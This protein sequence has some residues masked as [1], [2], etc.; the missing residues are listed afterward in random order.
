MNNLRKIA[1]ML[2]IGVMTLGMFGV[3][4][5]RPMAQSQVATPDNSSPDVS[6]PQTVMDNWEEYL[7]ESRLDGVLD[8]VLASYK[9]T[10]VAPD[11][12]ATNADGDVGVLVVVNDGADL[13]ALENLVQVNWKA[14]FKVATVVSAYVDSADALTELES[15]EGVA[16]VFADQTYRDTGSDLSARPD[17]EQPRDSEPQMYE[18]K[19]LVG[20]TDV[21]DSY[22]YD[23][24]DIRVGVVDTGVDFSHPDLYDAVDIDETGMPTS[25]DP[26]GFAE[27]LTLYRVNATNVENVTAYLE[28]SSWNLLSYEKDGKYYVNATGWDP[29]V[30]Y[31]GSV[32]TLDWFFEAYLGAWYPDGY[33]AESNLT[34]YYYNVLRQDMELP[35]PSLTQ[36][37][38]FFYNW[39]NTDNDTIPYY[40]TGYVMQQRYTPYAKIF[41]PALVLNGDMGQK[42]IIDWNTT[43]AHSQFWNLNI[44][45]ELMYFNE[46][47][48]WDYFNDLGDWSFV[49]D[50]D[51]EWWYNTTGGTIDNKHV[52]VAWDEDDDGIVDFGLGVL[53]HV[54][55]P[56]F[57][58]GMVDGIGL[59]GR[60]VGIMYDDD[61]HGTACASVIA[62]RG[63]LDYPVGFNGTSEK[64][65]GIANQSTVLG[66]SIKEIETSCF[67]VPWNPEV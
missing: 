8:S 13:A 58:I 63:V 12:V 29:Y 26:S 28:A 2:L 36:A 67:P 4:P 35:D 34:D 66:I 37:N 30:N 5:H 39:T 45:A 52:V 56:I 41:A 38:S 48:S 51:D 11:K 62:G 44:Y 64:L 60:L 9:E 17:L 18:V 31:Q 23:G 42:L 3:V 49:D 65:Y 1:V 21:Y 27:G 32:V 55:D 6:T 50:L 47:S 43:V 16:S 59:G 15:F 22:G 19:D 46:T 7:D 61:S 25:Y 53:A 57:G 54:W 14:D 20:G 24:S 33:P 40:C 10:G